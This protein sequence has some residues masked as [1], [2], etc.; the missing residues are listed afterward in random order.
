MR[1]A[2]QAKLPSSFT[3]SD[4]L[5]IEGQRL[6]MAV[7]GAA[8][9]EQTQAARQQAQAARD[10]LSEDEQKVHAL[11]VRDTSTSG[12]KRVFGCATRIVYP[13]V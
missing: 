12:R 4:E 5:A 13:T 9:Q 10:G 8:S 1:N 2:L 6:K 3:P 7:S 11:L